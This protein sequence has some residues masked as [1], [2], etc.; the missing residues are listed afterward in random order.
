MARKHRR[1]EKRARQRKQQQQHR[2]AQR[3]RDAAAALR[4]GKPAGALSLAEGA[5]A[6]ANDPATEAAARRL[7]VEA[8]FRL[9][10][11][12]T[13]DRQC[14]HHLDAALELAPESFRLR[15]HRAVTLCRLGR[16][17]EAVPEFEALAA[18]DAS[19]RDVATLYQ[20]ARAA[21]GQSGAN[22]ATA[23][24]KAD[25]LQTV[26]N[27]Q[28]GVEAQAPD[29]PVQDDTAVLW[30]TLR[31]MMERPKAAPVAQLRTLADSLEPTGAGTLAQ[32]YLG[33]AAMRAGDAETGRS[34]WQAAAAA[35]MATPWSDANHEHVFREQAHALGREGRWQALV[36]LLQSHPQAPLPDSTMTEL[37]SVA[38]AHL[39]HAAA[40]ANDWTAAA[41]HWQEVASGNV[42][43]RLLQNLAL[44]DEALGNW[45]EAAA[46]WR[47][48]VRRRPRKQ[49]H[50]DS[51]TD[52]Q[53]AALW[54][55]VVECYEHADDMDEALACLR[56][57][58]KYAPEDLDLRLKAADIA[59]QSERDTVAI[60]ELDRLLAIDPR[61][62]PALERLASLY[63]DNWSR[64]PIPIWRR[65]LDIEPQHEEAREAIAR[66]YVEDIEEEAY[67]YGLLGPRSRRSRK[68][69][70]ARLQEGLK[71]LPGHP[72]LL[73]E[74]GKQ[75]AKSNQQARARSYLE[76]AW[77]AA[78]KKADIVSE[79]M[80]DLLHVGGGDI[81]TRLLPTVREIRGL[82]AAF[83][84][85][86][87]RSALQCKLGQEWVD[88]FWQEAQALARQRR[89]G[90]TPAYVLVKIFDAAN[91]VKA[92]DVAA[93][94]EARLRAEHPNS[95]VAD[96]VDAYHAAHDQDDPD[97]AI[98]L[99]RKVQR[100]ARRADEEG[101][102]DLA[103]EV[104]ML[105][106][107]PLDP[108]A[109]LLKLFGGMDEEEAFREPR[110][111]W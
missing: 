88:L 64:N 48:V 29:E 72:A 53:V 1:R 40:R 76:Q 50:P 100:T 22:D 15:Y 101:I 70:I 46:T 31:H 98:R 92:P 90:D 24:A 9:A 95:G 104:I 99:L 75:H 3:L 91:A 71:E 58:L 43:R 35:G 21:M 62:V 36:D 106:T 110:R 17:A 32:Y 77:E 67:R 26:L 93:H 94:Y 87:G 85:E 102:A 28:P 5:F 30:Q 61:H 54:H 84:V 109:G 68:E 4:S 47:Q 60:N 42:D 66:W 57:A 23:A 63:T 44:A 45:S 52:A 111:R 69:R 103:E 78:P 41:Q 12:T 82:L 8:H 11:V 7:V 51:L 33:V 39:G 96:Y 2:P 19:R 37:L 89:H 55:H 83:W 65:V 34:A 73:V 49:N 80:H 107:T 79:A 81:V 27:D 13:S 97:R 14:L 59:M 38:H 105:L 20:L 74:L 10:A 16:V 108:L 56:T 18:Q 6:A 86:Q 25:R